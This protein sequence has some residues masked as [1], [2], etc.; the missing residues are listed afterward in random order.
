VTN[1]FTPL[2]LLISSLTFG[3]SSKQADFS[4]I[5][6]SCFHGDTIKIILNGYELITNETANSDFATGRTEIEIYQ[7]KAGLWLQTGLQKI[8]RDRLLITNQVTL[9]FFVND[10]K[11]T[12]TVDL[13]KGKILVIDNCYVKSDSG[14][15]LKTLTIQ[16]FKKSVTFE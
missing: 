1:Y 7:D 9:D 3:Q 6:A 13:R 12:K 16:Q 10:V 11:T 8:K 5:V 15:S 14:E 2:L 4:L